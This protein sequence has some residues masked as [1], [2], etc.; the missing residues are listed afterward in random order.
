MEFSKRSPSWMLTWSHHTKIFDQLTD[1]TNV[2]LRQISCTIWK[3]IKNVTV[4]KNSN[5]ATVIMKHTNDVNCWIIFKN[6]TQRVLLGIRKGSYDMTHI[7]L[8]GYRLWKIVITWPNLNI[9]PFKCELCEFESN[10][11]HLLNTHIKVV[12]LGERPHKC[13]ECTESFLKKRDLIRHLCNVHNVEKPFKCEY[14]DNAFI[15]AS[16]LK[17]HAM[18]HSG[19]IQTLI[20]YEV[21]IWIFSLIPRVVWLIPFLIVEFLCRRKAI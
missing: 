8:N 7:L 16:L 2:H 9:D 4:T 3:H 17:Q 15:S 19:K 1:V 5:A 10:E 6:T 12:H 11:R 13:Q 18:S 20:A 21:R 14:C